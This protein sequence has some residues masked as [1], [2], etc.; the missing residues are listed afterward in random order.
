MRELAADP[1]ALASFRFTFAL[2]RV[3]LKLMLRGIEIDQHERQRMI[4]TLES[5]VDWTRRV[6]EVYT[7]ALMGK[8]LNPGSWQQKAELLYGFCLLPVQTKYDKATKKSRPTTDRGALE[9]LAALSEKASPLITAL[10]AYA[11]AKKALG[12]LRSGV[13]PD[14][15]MR[16]SY[17]V[18][19]TITSR[20]ASRKNVFGRGTNHQNIREA[21]RSVFTTSWGPMPDRDS[22][23]IPAEYR[24]LL[25]VED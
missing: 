7:T 20:F 3:A 13:D 2:Q 5:A 11:D 9:K 10:L 6:V 24:G 4:L 22:F 18:A 16:S 25:P 17:L 8:P 21:W 23:E 12:V 14:G 15:R 19:A 1:T